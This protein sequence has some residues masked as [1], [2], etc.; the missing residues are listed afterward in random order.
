VPDEVNIVK[1]SLVRAAAVSNPDATPLCAD[2]PDPQQP[3]RN[4]QLR[5][6]GAGLHHVVRAGHRRPLIA[7]VPEIIARLGDGTFDAPHAV[8]RSVAS[9]RHGR[10]RCGPVPSS[11]WTDQDRIEECGGQ[12]RARHTSV[13]G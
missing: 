5:L 2:F 12:H 4:E 8:I 7:G 1:E 13:D 11:S 10:S 3:P 9:A 6:V